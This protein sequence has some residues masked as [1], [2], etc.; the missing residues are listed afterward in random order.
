MLREKGKRRPRKPESTDARHRCGLQGGEALPVGVPAVRSPCRS[1]LPEVQSGARVAQRSGRSGMLSYTRFKGQAAEDARRDCRIAVGNW[2][3]LPAGRVADRTSTGCGAW[4]TGA[5]TSRSRSSP[6]RCLVVPRTEANPPRK[7]RHPSEQIPLTVPEVRR[8][9]LQ[10]AW[11]ATH[12]AEASLQPSGWPRHQ[13]E[14]TTGPEDFQRLSGSQR[15]CQSAEATSSPKHSLKLTPTTPLP[16]TR[17]PFNLRSRLV[18]SGLATLQVLHPRW[19]T[20]PR[21][22]ARALLVSLHSLAPVH[23]RRA[24]T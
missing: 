11:P 3:A 8:L 19:E 16:A 23:R 24:G 21:E 7:R 10:V 2:R 20:W 15:S 17:R 5:V 1:G 22:G 14:A 4:T 13:A 9:L 12:S 18:V 6:T